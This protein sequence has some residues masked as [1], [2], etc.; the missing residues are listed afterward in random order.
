MMSLIWLAILM[1]FTRG[2]YLGC[3]VALLVVVFMSRA[4]CKYYW[5]KMKS[6]LKVGSFSFILLLLSFTFIIGDNPFEYA[7]A[8]TLIALNNEAEFNDYT[9]IESEWKSNEI[10]ATKVR[11]LFISIA[12]NPILGNG[13]GAAINYENGLVEYFYYDII[14]KMG[15]IGLL[16]FVLPFISMICIKRSPCITTEDARLTYLHIIFLAGMVYFLIIT[17][18][19]PSMNTTTGILY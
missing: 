9:S 12:D 17:A 2:I 7:I 6:L 11:L 1:S 14:N 19:N 15:I 16:L 3:F 18:S 4:K 5:T 13:L 10:R 8:R